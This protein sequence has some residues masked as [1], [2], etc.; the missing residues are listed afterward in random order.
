MAYNKNIVN[1][2]YKFLEYRAVDKECLL[3][4]FIRYGYSVAE[5]CCEST[6]LKKDNINNIID[7]LV[8]IRKIAKEQKQYIIADSIR[9][10]LLSAGIKIHDTKDGT[11]WR[12]L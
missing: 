9:E 4:I 5:H 2:I 7:T 3:Y 10:D 1:I 8:D 6:G 11:I 12:K